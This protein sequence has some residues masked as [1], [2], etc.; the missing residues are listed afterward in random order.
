[1]W[2]NIDRLIAVRKYRLRPILYGN[3]I[4]LRQNI[5]EVAELV[6][7]LAQRRFA[8]LKI[9]HPNDRPDSATPIPWNDGQGE[10]HYQDQATIARDVQDAA[11][12]EAVKMAIDLDLRLIG[13]GE[14]FGRT[15]NH[16]DL[17]D[18]LA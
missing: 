15:W 5:A 6:R 16:E 3:M 10:F 4:L 7:M 14:F 13:V 1:M 17:R 18:S 11:I 9:Y 2:T 12:L 8:H